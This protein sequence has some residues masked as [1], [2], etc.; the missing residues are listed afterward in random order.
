[1]PST[2][3][4]LPALMSG[5]AS[6]VTTLVIG[7]EVSSSITSMFLTTYSG[8]GLFSISSKCSFHLCHT[9]ASFVN[10]LLALFLTMSILLGEAIAGQS[11]CSFVYIFARYELFC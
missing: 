3:G 10:K 5:I 1:M 2:K 6:L 8:L 4:A 11:P 9:Y 7:S